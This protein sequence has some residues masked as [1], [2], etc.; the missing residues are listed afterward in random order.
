ME[1]ITAVLTMNSDA[2]STTAAGTRHRSDK[3]RTE[4]TGSCRTHGEQ[5]GE[6]TA[7]SELLQTSMETD[8]V[9][10]KIAVSS[11]PMLADGSREFY[12]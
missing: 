12:F 11:L 5:A 3:S 8:G 10:S 7:Y 4:A 2:A 1:T 9:V 6:I